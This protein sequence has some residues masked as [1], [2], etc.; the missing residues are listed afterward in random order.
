MEDF[1]E[2]PLSTKS[3]AARHAGT[4]VLGAFAVLY[5]IGILSAVSASRRSQEDSEKDR[6]LDLDLKQ[7]RVDMNNA[8][9]SGI[10]SGDIKNIRVSST[11]IN[12]DF[13]AITFDL[14][15]DLIA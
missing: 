13:A 1:N 3:F 8:I 2:T 5:G 9:T 11:Q 12:D 15:D 7:S 4:I 10:K 6:R 14:N